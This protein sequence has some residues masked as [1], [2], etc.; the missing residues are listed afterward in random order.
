MAK[1]T[2]KYDK[3][4]PV[5]KSGTKDDSAVLG[6]KAAL[7]KLPKEVQEKLKNIKTKLDKFQKR[8]LDKFDK[9]QVGDVIEC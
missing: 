4:G 9:Y 1:K 2:K 7:E 8:V 6:E 3:K 5:E